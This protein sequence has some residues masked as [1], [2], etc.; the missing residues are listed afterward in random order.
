[1]RLGII[2]TRAYSTNNKGIE[3]VTKMLQQIGRK[4]TD[5]VCLPEQWLHENR[6]NNFDSTFAS[7]KKAAKDYAMTVIAGAF[8]HKKAGRTTISAPVIGPDGDIIGVQDKIHPFD[9]ERN[10]ITP[11]NKVRVFKTSCKFGILICYD[12]VFSD[13][14]ESFVR[15]GAQV[16]F[17]PSRIVKRGIVPWHMYVQVR[18]L[19]N[20]VPI[21]AANMQ[22]SKFGGKS[23]IVDMNDDDGVMVPNVTTLTGQ[24]VKTRVFNLAKY[25]KARE[26]RYSDHQKFA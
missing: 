11:G 16:L 9:Y 18:A 6:L 20:R 7:F 24:A 3:S 10:L 1:M 25:D 22:D 14:A 26:I 21:L 5:I 8:Y 23:I 17:S 19:E 12:M 13:V 4:E 15:K 2:Q